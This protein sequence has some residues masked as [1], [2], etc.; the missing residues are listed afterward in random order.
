MFTGIITE[1][2]SIKR[3]HATK[4]GLRITFAI[5]LA[6]QDL[7]VGESIATDGVCLTVEDIGDNEYD[8]VLVPETLCK[9]TFGVTVPKTVNLE[10]A[11]TAGNRFGGHFVQGHVDGIGT[12]EKIDAADG[13]SLVI[14]FDAQNQKLVIVKGSIAINGVSLTIADVTGSS[15]RVALVPHTM[16]HTTF[17]TLQ[18]ADPVNLEFDMIGKYVANILKE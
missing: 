13:L 9:T 15:L 1:T 3:T 16:Q 4:K 2:S 5:P 6:W 12:V 7:V 10:R 8:C 18:I 14:S 11:L 17:N